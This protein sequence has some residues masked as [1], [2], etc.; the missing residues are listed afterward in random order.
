MQV[1][2]QNQFDVELSEDLHGAH[3]TLHA[4]VAQAIRSRSEGMMSDYNPNRIRGRI[5]EQI[6]AHLKLT[7]KDPA[8][9]DCGVG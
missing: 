8:I 9:A 6:N 5:A 1:P 2:S 3:S 7:S 4:F